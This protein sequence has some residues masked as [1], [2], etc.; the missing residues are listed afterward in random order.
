MVFTCE[1]RNTIQEILANVLNTFLDVDQIES[2]N[3]HLPVDDYGLKV[4]I[5][6]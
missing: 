3:G 1:T 2:C 5:F 4:C 6:L